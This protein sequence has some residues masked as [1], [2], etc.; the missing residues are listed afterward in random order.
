VRVALPDYLAYLETHNLYQVVARIPPRPVFFIHA[1][2]DEFV[3]FSVS[4][5][6][7]A[8]AGKESRLWLLD[9]GGHRGP[10]HEPQVMR[11]VAD[12]LRDRLR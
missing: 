9:C 10:R 4:D 6:L 3:P 5:R 12:W 8:Q 11:A 7:H 1:R 2:D